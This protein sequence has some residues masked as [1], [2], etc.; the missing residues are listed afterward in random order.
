MKKILIISPFVPYK[1]I[2]HAGGKAHCYYT[3]KLSKQY[4]VTHIGCATI[5]EKEI[6]NETI[7]PNIKHFIYYKDESSCNLKKN[8][9]VQKNPFDKYSGFVEYE[10]HKYVLDTVYQL[11]NINFDYV[12]IN[13]T[14]LIFLTKKLKKIFKYSF[15]ISVEHDVTFLKYYRF[16][17]NKKNF[18][19][20]IIAF[21]K[22]AN[23]KI[24]EVTSLLQSDKI[25]VFNDKDKEILLQQKRN[26]PNVDVVSPYFEKYFE[27]QRLDKLSK[28]IIFFGAMSRPENYESAIW[29]IENIFYEL[30]DS[31]EFIVIGNNP[32]EKL[33]KY[34]SKRVIITGFL[35]DIS[36]YLTSSLCMV[37]PLIKGAGIKI[38]ILEIMSS[39]LPVIT[40]NI[41]IEG[42]E[43][44]K[45]KD[46]IYCEKKEDYIN[47]IENFANDNEYANKIGKS[48]KEFIQKTYN[49][50]SSGYL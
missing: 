29:F 46:F 16:F 37:A 12:I 31:F 48:G 28:K 5:S 32:H 20:K 19:K 18:L 45:N 44:N 25:I 41:G 14:Q 49:E 27:I 34:S 9:F 3:E 22:Y 26:L 6:I 11:K 39:G 8:Q 13:F 4:D 47:A 23:L 21:Y 24:K 2:R 42:I 50:N 33:L 10:M 43:A 40:N 35:E 36:E 7:L 38:K 30:D 17:C 1:G 15:F